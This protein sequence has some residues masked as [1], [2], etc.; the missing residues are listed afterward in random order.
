ME[1]KIV[2]GYIG[3]AVTL[4]IGGYIFYLSFIVAQKVEFERVRLERGII[5]VYQ[6]CSEIGKAA[7]DQTVCKEFNLLHGNDTGQDF[8]TASE[9]LFQINSKL[10]T[11]RTLELQIIRLQLLP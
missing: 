6:F 2:F 11:E 9:G 8:W 10:N 7:V 5:S 3:M 4:V 1:K